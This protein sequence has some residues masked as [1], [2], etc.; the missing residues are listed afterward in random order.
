MT[1]HLVLTTVYS[2]K[3]NRDIK[4]TLQAIYHNKIFERI[5]PNCIHKTKY[6]SSMLVFFLITAQLRPGHGSCRWM[7]SMHSVASTELCSEGFEELVGQVSEVEKGRL[8]LSLQVGQLLYRRGQ[9]VHVTLVV[10]T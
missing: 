6:V 8:G 2:R 7:V 4:I 5:Q 10:A 9:H 3:E 1:L